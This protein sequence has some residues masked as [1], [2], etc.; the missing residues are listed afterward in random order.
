M[1]LPR[2]RELSHPRFGR[3]NAQDLQARTGFI[4]KSFPRIH[5]NSNTHLLS[6]DE[7]AHAR[8]YT[9][10]LSYLKKKRRRDRMGLL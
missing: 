8:Y 10:I 5:I 1:A 2:P 3:S 6:Q 7:N 9:P 4:S